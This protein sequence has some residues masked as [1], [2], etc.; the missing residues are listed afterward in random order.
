MNAICCMGKP[1]IFVPFHTGSTGSS[2]QRTHLTDL[3]LNW[4]KT[5]LR[6]LF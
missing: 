2:Q 3:L 1:K 5:E 6:S 4:G